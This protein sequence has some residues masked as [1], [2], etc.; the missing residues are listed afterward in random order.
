MQL[1]SSYNFPK[2]HTIWE[3]HDINTEINP[4]FLT[5]TLITEDDHA[6]FWNI[7]AISGPAYV[8]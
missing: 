2:W 5:G 3:N 6:T 1:E 4:S 8:K 7:G